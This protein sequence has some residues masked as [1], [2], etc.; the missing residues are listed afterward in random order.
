[1][2]RIVALTFNLIHEEELRRRPVDTMAEWDTPETIEGV[3]EA[4][5]SAGNEVLPI[6]ADEDAWDRLRARKDEI[7]IV[8]NLAEGVRGESRES[9]VPCMLEM[10]GIP[11]VGSGPL[12][13]AIALNKYRTKEILACHGVPTAR[14]QV[15]HPKENGKYRLDPALEYP[16]I[17]KLSS[18]GSCI[19][20]DYDSVVEN[21]RDL[22]KKADRLFEL[23]KEPVLIEKFLGGREFTIPILGNDPPKTLPIV[24]VLF[25]GEK[26][27]NVFF[28]DK[29]LEV[30]KEL[31]YTPPRQM[32]KSVCPADVSRELADELDDI[33]LRS[34]RALECRDW[35][36]MEIRLDERGRPNVLEL[37][38]IAGIAPGFW[39]P[40]SAEA[41]GIG[42]AGLINRI[43]EIAL[44]RYGRNPRER[45]EGRDR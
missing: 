38:P 29:D 27:I 45:T 5:E 9:L 2:R 42:Y 32:T 24:E 35:C 13:L 26:P 4:L 3:V 6:E 41:A 30:F 36:R 22:R 21:E 43:L 14:F 1:M 11:Y 16:L 12:T 7:D 37:N 20:L 19:G 17:V 31:N 40:R 8:F 28:P 39:F 23:Y 33:A 18:E 44:E 34:F 10:L 25:F 15:V